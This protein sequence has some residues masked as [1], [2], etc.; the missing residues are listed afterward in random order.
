MTMLL[1]LFQ[2]KIDHRW[3]VDSEQS[4]GGVQLDAQALGGSAVAS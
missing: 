3:F 2:N 1:I 4:V